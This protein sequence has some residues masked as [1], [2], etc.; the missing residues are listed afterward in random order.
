MSIK[1]GLSKLGCFLHI[2]VEDQPD[3]VFLK[4]S[5]KWVWD[6]KTEHLHPGLEDIGTRRWFIYIYL[7]FIKVNI[8]HL[9]QGSPRCFSQWTLPRTERYTGNNSS[10]DSPRG[11]IQR[12][13]LISECFVWKAE[14]EMQLKQSISSRWENMAGSREEQE[15]CRIYSHWTYH[16]LMYSPKCSL[17]QSL[18]KDINKVSSVPSSGFMSRLKWIYLVKSTRKG[19]GHFS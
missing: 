2:F 8:E 11:H 10:G 9:L 13:L 17:V 18:G 15:Q 7:L 14:R 4:S 12:S 3:T 1:Q 5:Q 6:K 16:G 19:P